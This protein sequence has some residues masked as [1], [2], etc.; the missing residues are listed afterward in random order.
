M[1][2]YTLIKHCFCHCLQFTPDISIIQFFRKKSKK[3]KST[4]YLYYYTVCLLT[5]DSSLLSP[6]VSSITICHWT[7]S[8]EISCYPQQSKFKG[9]LLTV[10]QDER[11]TKDIQERA[12]AKPD[13]YEP[14][15]KLLST[16]GQ[17]ILD[18]LGGGGMYT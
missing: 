4:T 17:W 15:I 8:G 13:V 10:K 2:Q 5:I 12:R 7:T 3:F 14:L 1:H 11:A 6:S 9:N 16:P 18:P